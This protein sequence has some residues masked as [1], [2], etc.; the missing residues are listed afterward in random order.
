M[1]VSLATATARKVDGWKETSFDSNK[2]R[3]GRRRIKLEPFVTCLGEFVS[4]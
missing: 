4:D 2:L 3:A 1:N